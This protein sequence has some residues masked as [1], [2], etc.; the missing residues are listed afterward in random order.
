MTIHYEY[1][2]LNAEPLLKRIR[3]KLAVLQPPME[4]AWSPARRGYVVTDTT[5]GRVYGPYGFENLGALAR[6]VGALHKG[7]R[8]ET[9]MVKSLAG[10]TYPQLPKLPSHLKFAVVTP[11]LKAAL[12]LLGEHGYVVH[13]LIN[14]KI[15]PATNADGSPY[16]EPWQPEV[17]GPITP[18]AQQAL[19]EAAH[20]AN[21]TAEEPED[22]P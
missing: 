7:E 2:T 6:L 20:E 1:I 14:G 11:T 19:D 15:R 17:T 12:E 22:L 5:G 13:Q 4:L 8:T 18:N 16:Q 3:R 9:L 21:G 10:V